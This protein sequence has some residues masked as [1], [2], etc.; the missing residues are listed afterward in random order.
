MTHPSLTPVEVTL[1]GERHLLLLNHGSLCLA[2]KRLGEK[3]MDNP[4][5]WETF[6]SENIRA[7]DSVA[8]LLYAG[9][10]HEGNTLTRDQILLR[11]SVHNLKE[12]SEAVA[13]A[14]RLHMT[15]VQSPLPKRDGESDPTTAAA[16][17]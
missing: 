12:V 2:E 14:I 9:M 4:Q 11:L 15:P 13:E 10:L 16:I 7:F 1:N 3:I 17:G 8:T 6:A 5:F